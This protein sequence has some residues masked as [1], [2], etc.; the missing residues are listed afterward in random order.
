[1]EFRIA[2][3]FTVSLGR[4]S[5]FTGPVGWVLSKPKPLRFIPLKGRLGL[6]DAPEEIVRR[7]G[8][9]AKSR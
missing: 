8:R 1:M 4:S 3:T 7:L 9:K 6:F 5:W 2:D